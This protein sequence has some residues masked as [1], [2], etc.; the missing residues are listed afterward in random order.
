MQVP[1]VN[2]KRGHRMVAPRG[3]RLEGRSC[4]SFQE[5]RKAGESGASAFRWDSGAVVGLQCRTVGRI[6]Q[7]DT[8]VKPRLRKSLERL[9]CSREGVV[10]GTR[11]NV[12]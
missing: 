2:I 4:L 6:E 3:R 11:A 10:G 5:E 12:C 7:S 1:D 9:A 8:H